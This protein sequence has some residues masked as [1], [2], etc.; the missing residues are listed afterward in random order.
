MR[1]QVS[2]WGGLEFTQFYSD[3]Q[4]EM[5][6]LCFI[7]SRMTDLKN[8]YILSQISLPPNVRS[9]ES[10]CSP[11]GHYL[12]KTGVRIH[13]VTLSPHDRLQLNHMPCQFYPQSLSSFKV[14]PSPLLRLVS[15]QPPAMR[16]RCLISSPFYGAPASH[17]VA[18]DSPLRGA[19]AG[20]RS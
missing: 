20:R 16:T 2:A 9:Q 17:H 19:Q 6:W 8:K 18:S 3:I 14:P 5:N 4:K 13:P 1:R 10:Y 15:G 7:R 12:L 11:A